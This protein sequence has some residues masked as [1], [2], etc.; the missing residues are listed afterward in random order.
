MQGQ[1]AENFQESIKNVISLLESLQFQFQLIED[2]DLE[3]LILGNL[4]TEIGAL[5]LSIYMQ[6]SVS[7]F[8]LY[9]FHPLTILEPLR[10]T[11]AEFITRANYGLP[12]GNFEMDFSDGELRYKVGLP[13]FD[14]PVSRGQF[15]QALEILINTMVYYHTPL[16]RTLYDGVSA[17][18][19]IHDTETSMRKPKENP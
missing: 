18:K 5:K 8:V 10:K 12:I 14:I 9:L 2:E 7:H 4:Q 11:A 17:E 16:I 1:T 3:W 13:V 6:K 19:A 15:A